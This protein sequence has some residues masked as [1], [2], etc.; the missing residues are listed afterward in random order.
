MT[1]GSPTNTDISASF[2]DFHAAIVA[3]KSSIKN[4]VCVQGVIHLALSSWVT[5][6]KVF[7]SVSR[8]AYNIQCD[9]S[10]WTK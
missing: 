6:A 7:L 1:S 2:G 10:V 5:L 3:K 8:P 4:Q 9:Q